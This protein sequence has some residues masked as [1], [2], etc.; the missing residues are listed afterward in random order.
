MSWSG[1]MLS[2]YVCMFSIDMYVYYCI[3]VL[4]VEFDDSGCVFD[5]Q[6]RA[7]GLAL[8]FRTLDGNGTNICYVSEMG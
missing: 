8:W 4:I 6:Y 5:L 2:M 1:K 7:A 3:I